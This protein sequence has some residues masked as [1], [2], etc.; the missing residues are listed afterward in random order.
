MHINKVMN[1]KVEND[2][3]LNLLPVSTGI[4]VVFVSCCVTGTETNIIFPSNTVPKQNNKTK[5]TTKLTEEN[6]RINLVSRLYSGVSGQASD[7][8]HLRAFCRVKS[9][10]EP[11]RY[12]EKIKITV[13]KAK[14][15]KCFTIWMITITVC[16][17]V[18]DFI[19]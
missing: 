4:F 7:E 10:P 16:I 8:T 14:A 9:G 19:F 18:R 15:L 12:E 2:A 3:K 17:T 11:G 5:T 1:E 13:L 6:K